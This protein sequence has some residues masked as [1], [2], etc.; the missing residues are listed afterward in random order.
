MK[1]QIKK[2]LALVLAMIMCMGVLSGCVIEEED[3][4]IIKATL[5]VDVE[6]KKNS[7]VYP[8][9]CNKTF[10]ITV[11]ATDDGY[12]ERDCFKRW[13]KVTGVD[14][15]I[16]TMAA[17]AFK[18]SVTTGD[19][20]D[21]VFYSGGLAKDKWNELGMA[22]R[23][24]NFM[25]Y[26]EYM[27]NF[28]RAL[29]TY[30]E[31]L[32]VVA[33]PN[34]GIYSLPRIGS[35]STTHGAVYVRTD[36][37]KAAGWDK[38]PETT[39][40]LMDCLFDLKTAF[41]DREEF[42]PITGHSATYMGWAN[43]ASL[44]GF[45]FPSF[46]DL[47]STSYVVDQETGKVVFGAGTEQY[48]RT[49]AY[50]NEMMRKGYME[51]G[52]D[53]YSEDGTNGTASNL[54]GNIAISPYASYMTTKQFASGELDMVLL[55]PLTSQYQ[56][57]KRFFANNDANWQCN[58]INAYLPEEDIITL[59]KWFDSM[60]AFADNPLNEEGTIYGISFWLG[61]EGKD[62]TLDK[63]AGTYTMLPH[64]GYESG[65]L[66]LNANSTS[67]ALA[68]YDT[69]NWMYV[70][71]SNTGMEVKGRDTLA[72]TLPY[73][74]DVF[75]VDRL[76]LTESESEVYSDNWVNLDTYITEWTAKFIVGDYDL[77]AK[78]DEYVRGLDSM[79]LSELTAAYQS[80][81]DRYANSNAE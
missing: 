42:Y 56:S 50:L 19:F 45:L 77:N 38:V 76:V 23:F 47:V 13:E 59:V 78:W 63:E 17:D 79:G 75:N 24:V 51:F 66:W 16:T 14:T 72:N 33:A 53:I 35:T 74:V 26:I 80:A 68:L 10:D 12:G 25:E 67:G 43:R 21:A 29:N 55:S 65:S 41:G 70:Q 49:L 7:E 27:P 9:D 62:F 2:V 71:A 44:L 8:L 11:V 40:E 48:K 73:A 58:G 64:E 22:G 46:G 3:S 37:L 1:K 61:E 18:L 69:E 60:Y 30:P 5:P 39:D 36:Y 34:G 32:D 28:A 6:Q 20:G 4:E 57:E 15:N 81:Y 52:A 54:A 31:A